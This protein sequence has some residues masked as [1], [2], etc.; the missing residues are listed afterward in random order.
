MFL[1]MDKMKVINMEFPKK[2]GKVD[3]TKIVYNPHLTLAGFSLE[4]YDYIVNGE[5]TVE[6]VMDRY[7]HKVD[8]DS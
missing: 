2:E 7:Q 5:S 3:K 6:W 4:A 8:K 1:D